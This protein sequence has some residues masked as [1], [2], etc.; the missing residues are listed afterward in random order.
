LFFD[1]VATTRKVANLRHDPRIAFV[2]G[3]T[4]P[5]EERTVQYEGVADEP[6]GADLRRL[7]AAYFERFPEGRA[8]ETWPGI[9]YLRAIP[10]WIRYSDFNQEPVEVAEFRAI[11]L[12]RPSA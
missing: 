8:R 4:A 12:R 7:K 1:T 10:T 2:I 3:G 9:V 5:G 11:E 6:A